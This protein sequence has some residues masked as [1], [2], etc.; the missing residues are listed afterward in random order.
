MADTT[1]YSIILPS[2][3]VVTSL[4]LVILG[5]HVEHIGTVARKS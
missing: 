5:T 2:I 3:F 1:S 4:L